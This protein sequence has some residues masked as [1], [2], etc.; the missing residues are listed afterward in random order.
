MVPYAL[1]LMQVQAV[2]AVESEVGCLLQ[3]NDPKLGSD[4]K[5]NVLD[6]KGPTIEPVDT[7]MSSM[8]DSA[9]IFSE[10]WETGQHLLCYGS[11]CIA[12]FRPVLCTVSP[13]IHSKIGH[14]SGNAS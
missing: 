13:H 4:L 14:S 9:K 8:L 6:F 10:I 7:R 1:G 11:Y 5:F 2:Q 12:W 3:W